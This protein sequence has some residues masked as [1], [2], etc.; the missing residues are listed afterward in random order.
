MMAFP[1]SNYPQPPL[2][3]EFMK[4]N[5]VHLSSLSSKGNA[6]LLRVRIS[7]FQELECK[8]FMK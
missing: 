8:F 5:R 4:I 2:K 3:L 6:S 7:S 1:A